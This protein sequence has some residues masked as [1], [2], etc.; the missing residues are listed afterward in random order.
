[1]INA[2][3]KYETI[4]LNGINYICHIYKKREIAS[5]ISKILK[6]SADREPIMFCYVIKLVVA[7]SSKRNDPFLSHDGYN[8]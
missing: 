4:C 7:S 8:Y 2:E 6:S 1:M 3:R 5:V